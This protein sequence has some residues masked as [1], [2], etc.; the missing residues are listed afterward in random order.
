MV[1]FLNPVLTRT[2][3]T[4]VSL[5][6]ITPMSRCTVAVR[7]GLRR[8]ASPTAPYMLEMATPGGLPSYCR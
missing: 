6:C 7:E 4:A 5:M 2:E 3:T 1:L 8:V